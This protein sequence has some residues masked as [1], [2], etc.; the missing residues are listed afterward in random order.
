MPRIVFIE[1]K[2]PDLHIYS[3][4]K[5]PRLG[6]L[7]LGSLMRGRGWEVEWI[8]EEIMKI[9][10]GRIDF[11]VHDGEA[12]ILDVNKTLGSGPTMEDFGEQLDNLAEGIR[13]F[14]AP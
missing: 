5:L 14:L 8:F 12:F 9:D 13:S 7:I 10:F 4:F 2:A 11:V 1:P 3:R 6:L